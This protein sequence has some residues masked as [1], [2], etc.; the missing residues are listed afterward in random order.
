MTK[1]KIAQS[2]TDYEK[3]VQQKKWSSTKI[4]IEKYVCV[5][6]INCSFKKYF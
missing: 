1:Y 3:L 2:K 6:V 5:I 4:T